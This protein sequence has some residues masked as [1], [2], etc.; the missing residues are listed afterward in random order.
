[1]LDWTVAGLGHLL[2][3]LKEVASGIRDWRHARGIK[4][5]TIL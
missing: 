2:H 1:L 3:G 4:P 5:P